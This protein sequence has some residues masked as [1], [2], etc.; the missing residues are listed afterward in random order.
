M[1][2]FRTLGVMID[3]SRNAVLRPET[4]KRF[5]AL[6]AKMGYNQLMLYTED[7]YEVEG[8]PYFGYLR[9]RYS[10]KELREIDAFCR[11]KGVELVPCIQTLAHLNGLARWDHYHSI[12]D[13]KDVLLVGDE[14][15]YQLI[16]RMFASLA[17]SFTSR[18]IH[19]GMDEAHDLGRGKY[20][21]KH[22]AV[23]PAEI[24]CEH[25]KRVCE[26]AEKHGFRP[27]MWG[28]MFYRVLAGGGFYGQKLSA[29]NLPDEVKN[30]VPK[31]LDLVHWDY[32]HEKV[33]DYD[34]MLDG[35]G[36][37]DKSNETV[38][39][40]G[41]WT[42]VGFTPHNDFS[43][44]ATRAAFTSCRSHGVKD[45]FL[46]MWGDDGGECSP[47]G[48]L[49]ALH[50]AAELSR[51]N[52]DMASIK[53][54]FRAIVGE[55]FDKMMA[56]DLPDQIYDP[57]YGYHNPSKYCLYN[58]PFR[59]ILNSCLLGGG[60]ET[61]AFRRAARRLAAYAAEGG[62]Y[63]YLFEVAARLTALDEVKSELGL[64]IRAA[65]REGDREALAACVRDLL[66]AARRLR[67][68]YKAYR[69][70]WDY[71]KKQQGFE[72][73]QY[74]LAGVERRLGDCATILQEYLDGK[75]A[76]IEE[77]DEE[78]LPYNGVHH[79]PIMLLSWR[80]MNTPSVLAHL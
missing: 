63:A 57:P 6:I 56:L 69:T 44:R 53:E 41:A 11:E 59:G 43:I 71:E 4:V 46:T 38:F 15:T 37:F 58:D 19:I 10:Q 42:W 73:Q 54:S 45:V 14:R 60:H 80:L 21:D 20:L 68:F 67:A 3:C 18:R 76:T 33:E 52:E 78:L 12:I 49:P 64:R 28:D 9:G 39:A 22:G 1:Q 27:M 16:D 35:Y 75:R 47:F 31:N 62:E 55:D 25:L 50:Y 2:G 30:A 8:E 65:Y 72:M 5:V 23:P 17:A 74:R 24:L 61:R 32:Y 66:L 26:L 48:V 13:Q 51:G 36:L 40:G 7:T 29:L 34:I 77:L 79:R 70:A